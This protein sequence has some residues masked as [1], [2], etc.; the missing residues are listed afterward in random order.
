MKRNKERKWL[1][2]WMIISVPVSLFLGSILRYLS[3]Q[4][5][6]REQATKRQQEAKNENS[7]H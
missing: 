3:D 1:V 6:A 4:D 7:V 2:G 5:E